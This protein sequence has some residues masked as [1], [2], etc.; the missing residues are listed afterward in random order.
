[1]IEFLERVFAPLTGALGWALEYVHAQGAPWWL[2]IA[3]LTVV[4]RS[5]LFPLTIRQVKSMRAMQDLKPDMD[6]IRAQYKDNRQKQ[7]EE[8]MKLYQER[9]VNPFG[10][11]FP[12]LVQ[13]PIFITMFYVIRSFGDTH[14]SFTSGGILWFQDLSAYDPFYILPVLSALT[15]LAA[16]EITSKHIDPQQRWIMRTLPVV[17]TIFLLTFPAGLFMYWITSN[18]VTLVQNYVIY[19]HGPGKKSPAAAG[20]GSGSAKTEDKPKTS[21]GS[22]RANG[23]S[24]GGGAAAQGNVGNGD[25]Q[26]AKSAKRKR[27]RK[28]KK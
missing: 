8:I 27:R 13:M 21:A 15:M 22:Q 17:F 11:C 5:I 26:A 14:P 3:I 19:N 1:M 4:V 18:L 9:Q 12:L 6:R 2:S 16:S 7:Q 24:S 20:G 23:S 25:A 28:K 10:S